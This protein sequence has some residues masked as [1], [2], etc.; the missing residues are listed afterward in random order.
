M[1]YQ[2]SGVPV[3]I[4]KVPSAT[5]TATP[6]ATANLSPRT[7]M[8]PPDTWWALIATAMSAGSATV[9][10]KPMAPAKAYTHR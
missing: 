5:P 1:M 4:R 2:C 9:V 6:I 7:V 8:V 10:E 3:T